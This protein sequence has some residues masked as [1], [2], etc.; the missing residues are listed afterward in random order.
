MS[1]D[2][3]S[4]ATQIECSDELCVIKMTFIRA[5]DSASKSRFEKPGMPTI[6]L[7]SRLST[8]ILSILVIP[9]MISFSAADSDS[10]RVPWSS[11]AKVFLTST[12]MP[13]AI[14]G[15]IVGG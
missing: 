2:L 5:L 15:W 14:T 9:R 7:P 12:G 10:I 8:A 3:S 1:A 13:R 6:P 4:M 11:G